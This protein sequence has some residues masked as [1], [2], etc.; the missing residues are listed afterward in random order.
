MADRGFLR[1]LRRAGEKVLTYRRAAQ[2]I[3]KEKQKAKNPIVDWIEAFIW[4]AGVVL[5]IN[6]YFF[7]AYQIPSGSMINTLEIKDRI[8]VNKLIYGPELLPGLAKLSSPVIPKRE[9][10]IIF[11]NPE[12]YSR[13]PGFDIAQRIIYMLTLSLVDIDR[14]E[15]GGPRVHFLIKRAAGTGGDSF[16]IRRGE[17]Y[18]RFPGEDRWVS[19]REYIKARGFTHEL[20]RLIDDEA[21]VSIEAQGELSAYMAMGLQPPID[22]VHRSNEYALRYGDRFA[23][24]EKRLALIRAALPY[25]E[26]Y[27]V[28]ANSLARGWYVPP[29][30]ILPLGD[31]RD[32]SQDGRFF[33]PVRASKILGRGSIIYWPFHRIGRIR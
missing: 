1:A 32:S 2:R 14:D 28:Q 11:E 31:N 26:R 25:H 6:Q 27:R 17:M 24:E 16:A 22:V 13:G 4:A 12:Y 3:K 9:D 15:S 20:S 18:I 23:A 30:R 33:G 29:G 7:Q 5:L 8:F 19:E 21:Y 10:V